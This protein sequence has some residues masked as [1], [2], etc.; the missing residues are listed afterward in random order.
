MNEPIPVFII[1]WNRPYDC[2]RT[3]W[4]FQKQGVPVEITV[5]DNGSIKENVE[6]L[7]SIIGDYASVV[8]LGKNLGFGPGL[9]KGLGTWLSQGGGDYVLL[10]AH[11][12]I[13]HEGC[14][15]GLIKAMEE[16]PDVG[17]ASAE[18]GVG[19]IACFNG[20]RGPYIADHSRGQGFEAHAFPNGTLMIC[21]RK[22]LE[23]IG[24]FD[25]QYFAY[26]DE[27]DLAIRAWKHGWQ[28]GIVW[29]ARVENPGCSVPSTVASYLQV[30]N[31]ILLVRRWKGWHWALL[32]SFLFSVNTFRLLF[33]KSK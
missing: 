25:N 22:C 32:R 9:N 5:L 19:Y 28:V 10:S 24:V 14:L 23:E 7:E 33:W 29:G 6:R 11:D 31:A 2:A 16:Y 15:S 3:V 26:G 27:V 18:F 17:I 4:E 21:R 13:P 30:R 20:W 1:H 8:R 12:A